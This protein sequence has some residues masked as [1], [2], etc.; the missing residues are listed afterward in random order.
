M[1]LYAHNDNRTIRELLNWDASEGANAPF[2]KVGQ[3]LL[4][5][6]QTGTEAWPHVIAAVKRQY[7]GKEFALYS[8]RHGSIEGCFHEN[9]RIPHKALCKQFFD[10][11]EKLAAS[12]SKKQGVYIDVVDTGWLQK[13]FYK[14][15]ILS[16]LAMKRWVIVSWCHSISSMRTIPNNAAPNYQQG[17]ELWKLAQGV[18]AMRVSDLVAADYAWVP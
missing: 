2:V 17:S 16:D 4:A 9:G 14:Q 13:V 8:G 7:N 6:D 1:T 10:D 18:A 11:D 15:R 5:V 12:E 3:L